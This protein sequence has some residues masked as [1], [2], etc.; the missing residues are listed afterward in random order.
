MT[1]NS[2]PKFGSMAAPAMMMNPLPPPP[3]PPSP[4][5]SWFVSS[6][7]PNRVKNPVS[8]RC[9]Y[10]KGSLRGEGGALESNLL[11]F[12]ASCRPAC[13]LFRRASRREAVL[14]GR[15][16]RLEVSHGMDRMSTFSWVPTIRTVRSYCGSEGSYRTVFGNS[17][18][19]LAR[20]SHTPTTSQLADLRFFFQKKR[21]SFFRRSTTPLVLSAAAGRIKGS[22]WHP[23][24]AHHLALRWLPY[25]CR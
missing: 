18:L 14:D 8:N 6:F 16:P 19:S 2:L 17:V 20:K 23:R 21:D 11:P 13:P 22:C 4:P 24:T 7:L 9:H 25:F 10:V 5:H 15:G 12:A 3:L 1:S